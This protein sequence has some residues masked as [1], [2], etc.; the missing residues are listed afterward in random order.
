MDIKKETLVFHEQLGKECAKTV[1]EADLVVPDSMPD[2]EKI[3][4]SDSTCY[5][6]NAEV[7]NGRILVHGTAEFNVL[8]MS[9][10]KEIRKLNTT[11]KI[12][13]VLEVSGADLNNRADVTL[14]VG[15]TE[16]KILNGRKI[17]LKCVAEIAVNVLKESEIEAVV[18]VNEKEVE[19]QCG[20]ISYVKKNGLETRKFVVKDVAQIAKEM[21]VVYEILSSYGKI[22]NAGYKII[23]NKV[24]IKAD[25]DT[26]ILYTDEEE[27]KPCSVSVSIPFTEVLDIDGITDEWFTMQDINVCSLNCV[28]GN[29]GD[30]RELE[31]EALIECK[32]TSM[33]FCEADIL[34]D[35]YG[36]C[37]KTETTKTTA[38]ICE[39]TGKVQHQTGIKTL[40]ESLDNLDRVYHL[41]AS[42]K[43]E[44]IEK[45]DGGIGVLGKTRIKMY[46]ITKD[47][48]VSSYSKEIPFK[49]V[50]QSADTSSEEGEINA[51]INGLSYTRNS[52]DDIEVRGNLELFGVLTKNKT[53]NIITDV[54]ISEKEDEKPRASLTV[55]FVKS[56]ERL[57]DIAK[58]Y[59]TSVKAI[60][61][62]NDLKE[63]EDLKGKCLVVPKYK[64]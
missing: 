63:N 45:N 40:A 61:E 51:K 55:C 16:C 29:D 7:Q 9:P 58:K 33:V 15:H 47:N 8:Y 53:Q 20:K 46:Y 60:C 27:R 31:I 24:I 36:I 2:V 35:C 5:L 25:L 13:D 62:A 6:E 4:V 48:L 50:L 37:H 17:S 18:N 39:V 3:L 19:E 38:Q 59:S 28:S 30:G 54:S 49:E 52:A 43:V 41:S 26:V 14:N 11:A 22:S 10:E 1:A 64:L 12:T 56:D 23:N 42:A 21:P 44:G 57:W 34:K 32:V